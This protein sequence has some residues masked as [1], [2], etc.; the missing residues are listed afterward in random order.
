MRARRRRGPT[1]IFWRPSPIATLRAMVI[2]PSNPFLSI[3]PI[4]ALPGVRAAL[5]DAAAPVIAVS[6]I[7]AGDAV[8]GPTAKMMRELGIAPSAAAVAERYHDFLDL[9]VL[10]RADREAASGL[11][12]QAVVANT[13]M[14]TLADREALARDGARSGR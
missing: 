6:P 14:R 8:K 3:E 1:R 7:I 9:Y 10:D 4:L 2:C 5:A 11:P 13:L 12:V